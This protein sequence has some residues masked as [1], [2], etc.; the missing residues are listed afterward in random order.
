MAVCQLQ[1]LWPYLWL[2]AAAAVETAAVAAMPAE[3]QRP[4]LQQQRRQ[5]VSPEQTVTISNLRPRLDTSGRP[6]NAH[7]GNVVKMGGTYFMYGEYY[8]TGPYVVVGTVTLPRLAVYHSQDMVSWVFGGLLHNNT[9]AGKGWAESGLWAGA[10]TDTG[11]WWCPW[12]VYSEARQKIILWWTATP[13]PCCDAF[14]GVAESSDGIHFDLISLNETGASHLNS[15]A[16]RP[17]QTPGAHDRPAAVKAALG[18]GKVVN[19]KD[20]NAVLIDDDGVGYIAYTAMAPGV[21]PAPNEPT[22]FKGDHMVAIERLT[23]DLLHSTKVQVGRLF[24]D[25]FVEGVMIFKRAG[26]YYI[27]YSSC[28][29]AGRGGSG[30]VVHSAKTISG[31]WVQQTRDVNCDTDAPICGAP[32]F[33][34]EN[35]PLAITVP[36]QGLGLSVIG[37]EYIWQGERWLSAPH[38]PSNC[39]SLCIAPTGGCKQPPGYVKGHDFSCECRTFFFLNIASAC[40]RFVL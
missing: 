13:G 27:I 10:A 19:P 17:L 35:R 29:C 33:P 30:A 4:P 14:W 24:P 22:G 28:S 18:G 38:S 39:S 16:T 21:A 20:G 34:K 15:S 5:S 12:A 3:Q 31:P 2:V 36:A 32:G 11:T 25:D 7:S 8:G 1:G 6:V 40:R 9:G 37:G 26:I 23:P